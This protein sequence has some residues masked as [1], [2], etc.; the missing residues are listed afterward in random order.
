MTQIT[1]TI[2]IAI[3]YSSHSMAIKMISSSTSQSRIKSRKHQNILN[4]QNTILTAA[5]FDH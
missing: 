5:T 1:T 2:Y 4:I 3:H